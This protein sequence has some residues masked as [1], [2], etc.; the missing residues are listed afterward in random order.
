MMYLRTVLKPN[1]V[2]PKLSEN[3][4]AKVMHLNEICY[5]F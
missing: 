2:F 5:T 3:I 1:K 4:M